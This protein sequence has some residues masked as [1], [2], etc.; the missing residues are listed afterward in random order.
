MAAGS[1]PRVQTAAARSV[2]PISVTRVR[3]AACVH[4]GD[5]R[6]THRAPK[7]GIGQRDDRVEQTT[8]VGGRHAADLNKRAIQGANLRR[9]QVDSPVD[10]IE[11]DFLQAC[12]P[13]EIPTT[14]RG[15]ELEVGLSL[16]AGILRTQTPS[17]SSSKGSSTAGSWKMV[18]HSAAH[19][20]GR[21]T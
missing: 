8:S 21:R 10:E 20:P 6:S 5:E 18:H 9:G 1:L 11:L 2:L 4:H 17:K 12:L 13:G 15:I 16:P 7:A 3:A 14:G 19:P